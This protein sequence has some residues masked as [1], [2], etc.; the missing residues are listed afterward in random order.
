MALFGVGAQKSLLMFIAQRPWDGS[1]SAVLG[2]V[3]LLGKT[4]RALWLQENTEFGLHPQ[5]PADPAQTSVS[6]TI[7]IHA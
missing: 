3:G 7:F 1:I 6:N 4:P 5:P 2:Q